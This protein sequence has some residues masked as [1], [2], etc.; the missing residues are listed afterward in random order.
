[1]E[2]EQQAIEFVEAVYKQTHLRQEFRRIFYSLDLFC[3]NLDAD[4]AHS[5]L[6]N[7]R[8]YLEGLAA[9][10][11]VAEQTAAALLPLAIAYRKELH[12]LSR[13]ESAQYT[14]AADTLMPGALSFEDLS[15]RSSAPD[16]RMSET[17]S[18]E[19]SMPENSL[20]EDAAPPASASMPE[21]S[22]FEDEGPSEEESENSAPIDS[23]RKAD[24]ATEYLRWQ[25]E[26]GDAGSAALD[27]PDY[28]E[29]ASSN[30]SSSPAPRPSTPDDCLVREE[31][32]FFLL[33]SNNE[34]VKASSL[35]KVTLQGMRNESDF[36]G[37]GE[38][39][40]DEDPIPGDAV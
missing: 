35:S 22:L 39:D 24:E 26:G 14:G 40:S 18:S 3:E 29:E 32:L 13:A 38:D 7:V 1:M 36:Y 21:N 4:A 31:E 34:K 10:L 37:Q 30:V 33:G 19:A 16:V 6:N 9:E 25:E 8:L 28:D 5:V 27:A 12:D 11:D 15:S 20:F 2:N 23:G 17:A